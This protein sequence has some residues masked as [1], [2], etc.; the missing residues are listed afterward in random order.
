M[1]NRSSLLVT[2]KVGDS[3]WRRLLRHEP[4]S[5]LTVYTPTPS[6]NVVI[7]DN[8][9]DMIR[10]ASKQTDVAERRKGTHLL[11]C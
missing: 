8:T 11:R 1:H 7:A 6:V 3:S 10:A 4:I 2:R 5:E 9:Q